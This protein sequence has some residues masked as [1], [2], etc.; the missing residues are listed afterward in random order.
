MRS[1]TFT[2]NTQTGTD[3][4]APATITITEQADGTLLFSVSNA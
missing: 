3:Q 4:M 2:L 1:L